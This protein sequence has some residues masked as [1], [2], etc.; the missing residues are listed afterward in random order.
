MVNQAE[1]SYD[2]KRIESGV[3]R[4]WEEHDCYHKAK[5]HR[6]SCKKYFFDDGPPYTTGSIHIGTAWNK[7]LKDSI[8]RYRRMNCY[9]VRDQP[10]FDM[11]GLPIEVKVEQSLGIKNKKQIESFGIEKFVGKCREF[12]TS[13]LSTMTE[14]FKELGVWMDWAN[15]YCTIKNDYLES[16]WWTLKRAEERRLLAQSERV[17]PWCLRCE[18]ALAEAELEYWNE[19][20]PSIYVKFKVKGTADEYLLIWTT[21]P[22]TLPADMMVSAFPTF[23]YVKALV[24]KDGKQEKW[25]ILDSRLADVA[26][27]GGYTVVKEL[28]MKEGKELEGL[29]YVHPLVEE[30]PYQQTITQKEKWAHKVVLGEHVTAENTGLVHTAPGHGP[31]DFEI[32]RKY[33]VAPFCPV[34][35][36]GHFTKEAGKYAGKFT[37]DADAEIMSDLTKKGLM[38]HQGKIEHRYGHCWRCKTGITYRT[39]MQWFLKVSEVKQ[40]M[41]DEI[42]SVKWVPD[43]VG[44]GRMNDWVSNARD[45]C[46]SRQRYW[47]IP[48]PVWLCKNPSCDHREVIGTVKELSEKAISG[49]SKGMDLHRPGIDAVVLKCPKCGYEMRRIP[50]ILDVWFDS[51]CAAW[52][53]LAYPQTDAHIKEW[54]E[55]AAFIT[56]AYEQTRGWYYS[57]LGA[58]T[59]AFGHVPYKVCLSHGLVVDEQ[60]RKM[61]KSLG[62]VVQPKDV[63]EKYGIDSFRYYVLSASAPWD[64]LAFSKDDEK[65][66]GLKNAHRLFTIF[67]N[68]Y[69][70]GTT[71]M[72]LDNFEGANVPWERVKGHLRSED[73]WVLSRLEAL[74]EAMRTNIDSYEMQKAARALEYFI[75][76]ELSRWYV[77]LIRDRTWVEGEDLDKLAAYKVLHECLL[78]TAKLMA[79]ITP[80][81]S[82]EIY[83]NLDGSMLSVHMTDWPQPTGA[84]DEPLEKHME[85]VQQIVESASNARQEAKVKLRWPVKRIVVVAKDALVVESVEALKKTLL[86]QTNAKEVQVVPP[87]AQWAEL[88]MTANPKYNALGPKFKGKAAKVAEAIRNANPE[89]LYVSLRDGAHVLTI[90][91]EKYEITS[92][93]VDFATSLPQNTYAAE[94]SKGIVYLDAEMTDEIRS[95]GFARDIIRR[96]QEMRKKANL[97]VEQLI[98]AEVQCRIEIANLIKPRDEMIRSETRARNLKLSAEGEAGKVEGKIV[99]HWDIEG[100]KFN[101]AITPL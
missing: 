82:E 63:M 18:T 1:K 46:I 57:Q 50:D 68:V 94:F 47:G 49:Y 74:K 65:N 83:H 84:R 36:S 70:F 23:R 93:M 87:G 31:E 66:V 100:E 54:G 32:G 9:D 95:E 75:L 97:H 16:A 45:W 81:L 79:P 10:G 15:P 48:I 28:E 12:A 6:A 42:A 69:Y 14:Q 21:T 22:W 62:N 33:G 58:G 40:R 26:Q 77:R 30:V 96:I 44:S 59:V 39:T 38:E 55:Q 98:D 92:S 52:A 53:Q 13:F 51:A 78:T 86:S 37:K 24:E 5:A 76:E 99:T 7:V 71:Y 2:P 17:L 73:K 89:V 72:A 61:S 43:W 11:H 60:G 29:E 64:D 3:K 20:D 34:D 85:I 56:E 41:L 90:E 35:E 4:Y 27:L 19:V 88:M 80:F 91:G 8:I 101:I 25:W 67:W